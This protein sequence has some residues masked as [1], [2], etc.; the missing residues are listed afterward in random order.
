MAEIELFSPAV[1]FF[2]VEN[3]WTQSRFIMSS[4]YTFKQAYTGKKYNLHKMLGC[5][6]NVLFL[7][8]NKAN[9]TCY[10]T[11]YACV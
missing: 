8:A 10:F 6:I 11:I 5:Y 2:S 7:D 3:L 4:S 9:F 1:C